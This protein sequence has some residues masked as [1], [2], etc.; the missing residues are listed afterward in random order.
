MVRLGESLGLGKESR[1]RGIGRV[2]HLSRAIM[3]D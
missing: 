2:Q 1:K 3:Q